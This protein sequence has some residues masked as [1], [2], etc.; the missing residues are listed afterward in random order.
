[1]YKFPFLLGTFASDAQNVM[2]C[3]LHVVLFIL[4]Y[5]FH[6]N[7]GFEKLF[8]SCMHV[9]CTCMKRMHDE[10][11]FVFNIFVAVRMVM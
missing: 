8:G 3:D 4:F 1:M 5:L 10:L 2:S 11:C 7:N 9:H 6:R